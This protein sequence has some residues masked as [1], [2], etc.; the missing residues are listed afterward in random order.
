MAKKKIEAKKMISNK[1]AEKLKAFIELAK[2]KFSID[3]I[4][5]FFLDSVDN[6]W[7][8]RTET[9]KAILGN[10]IIKDELKEELSSEMKTEGFFIV[11]MD[12]MQ[13][14]E[15]L[16]DFLTTVIYPYYNEQQI[17]LFN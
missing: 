10:S 6:D 13:Q 14:K 11:K 15:K 16:T 7:R 1:D 5:F 9:V 4:L 17:N 3:D 2:T 8:E 12:N